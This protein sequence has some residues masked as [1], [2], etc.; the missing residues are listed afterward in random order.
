[1]P[2]AGYRVLAAVAAFADAG[3]PVLWM[4]GNHDCW[5]GSL[6]REDVG[7]TYH[8]GP[9]IGDIAGWR[10]YVHHGDGLRV[11]EDRRYRAL[12][13]LLRNR[14]AIWAFRHLIHP[15]WA[16]RLALGSSAASRTYTA[17]D[18]GEGLR[19]IGRTLLADDSSLDLVLLG[20]SHVPDLER[21]ASGGV[22]ANAGTWLGD[23]TFL[24]ID[25]GSVQ[26]CRWQGTTWDPISTAGG[27]RPTLSK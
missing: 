23:S 3:I 6:I 4:A 7:A 24:R 10:A 20:H 16:S 15:D 14:A 27:R 8:A 1:M 26:L 19:K 12:R 2:R 13:R 22:I 9:W 25:E 17:Q 21:A 11:E 18:R 5:G